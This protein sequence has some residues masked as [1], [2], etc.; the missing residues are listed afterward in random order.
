MEGNTQTPAATGAPA[1]RVLTNSLTHAFQAGEAGGN[2]EKSAGFDDI[3]APPETDSSPDDSPAGE[4]PAAPE[5]KTPPKP[6]EKK[7]P[8]SGDIVA[9][10]AAE[11]G[12]DPANSQHMKLLEKMAAEQNGAPPAQ[13]QKGTEQTQEDLDEEFGKLESALFAE[14]QVPAQGAPPQIQPGLPQNGGPPPL[15]PGK[16]GDILDDTTTM[17]EAIERWRDAWTE[18][19]HGKVDVKKAG[20]V[21]NA[22]F[23]RQF[24]AM[25][26]PV[27]HNL[28]S[29]RLQ[30]ELGDALHYVR[31][32]RES[33]H[34]QQLYAG[35]L[36][37]LE[38]LNGYEK[39]P[40][41]FQPLSDKRI[42]VRSNEVADTRMNRILRENPWIL[43]IQKEDRDPAKALQKTHLA[44]LQAVMRQWKDREGSVPVKDVPKLVETG[45]EIERKKQT[46]ATR[47][48]INAGPGATGAGA[49]G[50]SDD[51]AW[52]ESVL[53]SRGGRTMSVRDLLSK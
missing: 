10:L 44:R 49:G 27:V 43:D 37:K 9:Q 7:P 6:E 26:L 22:F 12:L 5:E 30:A 50:R 14:E 11:F 51:D 8:A 40:E 32:Q 42:R 4:S 29:Q 47:Q 25:G 28:I 21:W 39:L 16:F 23:I 53:K 20:A 18:D 34:R 17:E 45:A 3:F 1:P 31:A 36:S 19:E 48:R 33:D 15:Q 24:A 38:K 2:E 35:V 52:M 41:L 13:E 46:D